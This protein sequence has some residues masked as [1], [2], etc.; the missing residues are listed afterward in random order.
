MIIFI[1]VSGINDRFSA[2]RKLRRETNCEWEPQRITYDGRRAEKLCEN[3][4]L[5]PLLD[6]Y[7]YH[8]QYP[9]GRHRRCIMTSANNNVTA[10]FSSR[11]RSFM[12]CGNGW[13]GKASKRVQKSSY[14]TSFTCAETEVEIA[15]NKT[16]ITLHF[17]SIIQSIQLLSIM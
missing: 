1:E 12:Y 13:K 8:Y 15:R 4:D 7:R 3:P 9:W 14:N 2:R 11:L 5:S 16:I 10:E 6:H 17:Y